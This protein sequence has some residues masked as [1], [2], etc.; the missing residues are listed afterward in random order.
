[1]SKFFA[2]ISSHALKASNEVEGFYLATAIFLK[3]SAIVKLLGIKPKFSVS[4]MYENYFFSWQLA[5]LFVRNQ[6]QGRY[7]KE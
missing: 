1:M 6:D 4:Q 7:K 3:P 5:L 2:N